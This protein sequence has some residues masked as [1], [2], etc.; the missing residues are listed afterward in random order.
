MTINNEIN[1]IRLVKEIGSIPNG[2]AV[3]RILQAHGLT[4]LVNL[5]HN[6]IRQS[7]SIEDTI[8]RAHKENKND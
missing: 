6:G 3:L 4:H 5:N 1:W 8:D 7:N 2:I